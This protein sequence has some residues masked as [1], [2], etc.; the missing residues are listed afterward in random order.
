VFSKEIRKMIETKDFENFII[1]RTPVILL[2]NGNRYFTSLK[3]FCFKKTCKK[4]QPQS[5]L[6][7]SNKLQR[8]KINEI[9]R[10][11]EENY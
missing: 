5:F 3:E 6:Q 2:K 4:L 7:T 11:F 10:F 8:Q 9:T 1:L